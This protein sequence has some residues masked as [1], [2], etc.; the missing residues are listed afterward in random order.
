VT[1]ATAAL[2]LFLGIALLVSPEAIPGLTLPG[3]GATME[4]TGGMMDAPGGADGMRMR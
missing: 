3:S 2:L 1:Y 4:G